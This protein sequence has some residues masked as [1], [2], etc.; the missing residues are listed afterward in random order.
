MV[1]LAN[2]VIAQRTARSWIAKREVDGLKIDRSAVIIQKH[3]RCH[4]AHLFLLQELANILLVQAVAW[5]HIARKRF[6]R[7]HSVHRTFL[8]NAVAVKIQAA[9]RGFWQ[10]SHYIILKY[11]VVRMQ[12]IV[13]RNL[14]QKDFNLQLGCCVLIQSACRRYLAVKKLKCLQ[15]PRAITLAKSEELRERLA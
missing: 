4:S 7:K 2:V 1:N 11:E 15:I 12:A 8:E 14:F 3:W 13:R 5:R 6:E 10:Y 9:W